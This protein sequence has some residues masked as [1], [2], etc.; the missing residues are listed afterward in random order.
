MLDHGFDNYESVTLFEAGE[1][2]Y[3]LKIMGGKEAYVVLSNKEDISMTLPK[4]RGKIKYTVLADRR[5]EFAPIYQGTVY[6]SIVFTADDRCV[7]SPLVSAYDV[8]VAT[9]QKKN[10]FE[11]IFSFLSGLFT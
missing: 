5:I 3:P 11:M 2:R 8:P 9:K 1:F 7:E 6:G 10:I 4:N